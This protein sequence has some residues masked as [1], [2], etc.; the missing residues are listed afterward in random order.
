MLT[1]VF[2][3]IPWLSKQFK[4]KSNS[5]ADEEW[6][7]TELDEEWE[8]ERE[9][10]WQEVPEELEEHSVI[11]P[12]GSPAAT[13]E[14]I[15]QE[16]PHEDPFADERALF[17]E[18][19]TQLI[20]VAGVVSR[21]AR[22][23]RA[24]VPFAETIDD[25]VI[26]RATV[27][28]EEIEE[29]A[30]R[31][32]PVTP[33][34]HQAVGE[35]DLVMAQ[36]EV[37][38]GQRRNPVLLPM[39]GDADALAL[40]CYRSTLD[41]ACAR[42]LKL[43]SARPV[44]Q[45]GGRYDLAIWTGFIPTGLA[46]I[47]LPGGFFDNIMFWP[48]IAHEIG[49]DFLAATADANPRLRQQLGLP[50]EEHGVRPLDFSRGVTPEELKRIFGGWFEEI[51]CDLFGTLML[52]PAYGYSMAA[53]F[54]A[55]KNPAEIM[56]VNTDDSGYQYDLHP[57]RHLR[58]LIC[59]QALELVGQEDDAEALRDQWIEIHGGDQ[60]EVYLFPYGNQYMALPHEPIE[61]I[62]EELVQRLYVEQLQ[63]FSGF[64]LQDIPGVDF[65]PAA[66]A[67]V[68]RVQDQLQ[69]GQVPSTTNARAIIAGG[70]CA[71]WSNPDRWQE[72]LTLA[73]RAIPAEGT[74]ESAPDAYDS[75]SSTDLAPGLMDGGP[76][77]LRQAFMLHTIL[78]RP[79]I[80]RGGGPSGRRGFLQR[81]VA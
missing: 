30:R 47:F 49:H 36:L 40:N 38:I 74:A 72:F 39:L 32:A 67:R 41:F 18:R 65:G 37:F 33:E 21:D 17:Q 43:T 19:L 13:M 8:K 50:S 80:G 28:E 6:S 81:R 5:P 1:F 3:V 79:Q 62:A 59:A 27:L 24:I 25:F 46:P 60:P 7:S 54:A 70:V 15:A 44:T 75:A 68:M 58:L 73:R 29:L 69:A 71:C 51:F 63:A 35:L 23:E 57:P 12:A 2:Y 14:A 61:M 10:E 11:Y 66:N 42:D 56:L 26:P 16:R 77:D 31:Q 64:R 52:G 20:S 76:V 34:L 48:A 9:E 4:N 53:L 22:Q 55:P 78:A 45:V